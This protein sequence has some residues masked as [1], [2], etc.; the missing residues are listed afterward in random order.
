MST[1]YQ[2]V[3]FTQGNP[4]HSLPGKTPP[5]TADAPGAF[6]GPHLLPPALTSRGA[7][8]HLGKCH[9]ASSRSSCQCCGSCVLPGERQGEV[10]WDPPQP[11]RAP[12]WCSR[13]SSWSTSSSPVTTTAGI[14]N[15]TSSRE[16][17]TGTKAG[18]MQPRQLDT[19]TTATEPH[20]DHPFVLPKHRPG[21]HLPGGVELVDV[22]DQVA[23]ERRV[24][25]N[26]AGVGQGHQ[27]TQ[28]GHGRPHLGYGTG[29]STCSQIWESL[30]P[31]Q[32]GI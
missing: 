18:L 14:R 31:P 25:G 21:T 24:V 30:K 13:S 22:V 29:R 3:S 12:A 11:P 5:P 15:G 19:Q 27:D 32:C 26:A 4:A 1:R 23:G 9:R 16:K 20:G 10:A 28:D 2:K 8:A 17:P 6:G 7:W